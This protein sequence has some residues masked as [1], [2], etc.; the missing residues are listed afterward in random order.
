M[1]DKVSFMNKFIYCYLFM[2]ARY[3]YSLFF[4][5]VNEQDRIGI[6]RLC[7]RKG[8]K[9]NGNRVY[10]SKIILKYMIEKSKNESLFRRNNI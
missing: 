6:A 9:F 10:G 2:G 5:Y 7:D 1:S 4:K 3:N 8:M